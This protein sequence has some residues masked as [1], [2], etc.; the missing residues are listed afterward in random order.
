MYMYNKLISDGVRVEVKDTGQ[1]NK[2]EDIKHI[3]DK[4]YRSE[5][6]KEVVGTV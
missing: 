2:R 6:H 1:G 4:Y 3:F 5:N